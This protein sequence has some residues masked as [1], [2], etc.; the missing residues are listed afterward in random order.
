MN[1]ENLT[2]N[3][4]TRIYT[5][6]TNAKQN[7]LIA[8]LERYWSDMCDADFCLMARKFGQQREFAMSR[9]C[10]PLFDRDWYARC[11]ADVI[12][13]RRVKFHEADCETIAHAVREISQ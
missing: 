6:A 8:V 2:L 1:I 9:E 3:T 10:G 7:G 5:A 4:L 12:F 13:M 11:V